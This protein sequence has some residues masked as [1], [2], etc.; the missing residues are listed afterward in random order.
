MI[1][2]VTKPSHIKPITNFE[3]KKYVGKWYEIA[4]LD[5]SFEKGKTDVYAEYSLKPNGDIQVVNSGVRSKTGKRG[6]SKF[7]AKFVHH[8]TIG[9][10]KLYFFGPF[11][12][13]YV[14]FQV[15]D[16]YEYAYV[17]G[18]DTNYLWLLARTPSV[19]ESVKQDFVAKAH[20]LG[21]DT[22]KLIWVHHASA[23]S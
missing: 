13:V 7:V 14:V 11:Y 16:A 17:A 9:Y 18:N 2:C 5:H 4:R 10:L 12:G 23:F 8:P 3:A 21:F 1:G 22:E 20:A 15:D 6:Y 19:P